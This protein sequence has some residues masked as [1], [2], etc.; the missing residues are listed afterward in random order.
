VNYCGVANIQAI[1]RY[2]WIKSG[3]SD[4]KLSQQSIVNILNSSS[5]VSP[6]GAAQTTFNPPAFKADIAGDTGT[7]PRSITWGVWDVTP[8]GYYFHN[9]IYSGYQGSTNHS[10][11]YEVAS[12]FGPAHGVNDPVSITIWGGRHSFVEDGVY[13]TSDPSAGGETVESIDLWDPAHGYNGKP[14][15]LFGY[16]SA[17]VSDYD[18]ENFQY[19]SDPYYYY[20]KY[21]YDAGTNNYLKST[22]GLPNIPIDPGTQN[23][24]DPDPDTL[25]GCYYD[26]G[27]DHTP[28]CNAT[29]QY[30]WAVGFVT[31]EQDYVST[32]TYS[33]NYALDRYGNLFLHNGSTACG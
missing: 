2:D 24:T 33:P 6:W 1:D 13:A 8:V 16:Q 21:P 9:Y 32:C 31:I 7:D 14:G 19:S 25:P 3:G 27:Y 11:T 23:S 30:H 5:A 4:P 22:I 17:A 18:W 15:Y 26:M 29:I 12:D 10:A 20:W 28:G